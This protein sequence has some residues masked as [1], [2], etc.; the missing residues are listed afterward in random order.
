MNWLSLLGGVAQGAGAFY[1][2]QTQQDAYDKAA[3]IL[4]QAK[5]AYGNVSLPKLEELVGKELGPSA[6]EQIRPQ[7]KLLAAQDQALGKLGEYGNNQGLTLQDQSI[8]NA[9]MGKVARQ[10]SAGR[11]AIL[12]NMAARGILGSGAELAAGLQNQQ[13][14]AERGNAAGLDVA[15]RAQERAL[16]ALIQRGQ[17]AG[18][19]REQDFREQARK[20]EAK[21]I[22]NRY[23]ATRMAGAAQQNFNNRIQLTEG[24][25]GR[26]PLLAQNAVAAGQA[27][28][29]QIGGMANAAAGTLDAY[30]QYQNNQK[31]EPASPYGDENSAVFNTAPTELDYEDK[32]LGDFGGGNYGGYS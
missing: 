30:A 24:Q 21:D 1:G 15:G 14:A 11:N 16:Q 12:Q 9:A 13:N 23:N 22:I 20:A 3:K 25:L 4:M 7:A 17:M 31:K 27:K 2:G 26:D 32:K 8:L 5:D 19:M 10:E 29:Q 18:Q 28:A 6:F